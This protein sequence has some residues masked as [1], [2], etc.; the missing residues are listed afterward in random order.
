MGLALRKYG[1]HRWPRCQ[2]FRS[3]KSTTPTGSS[4]VFLRLSGFHINKSFISNLLVEL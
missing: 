2:L 4:G 3:N 1:G